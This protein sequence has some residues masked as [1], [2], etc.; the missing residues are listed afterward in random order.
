MLYLGLFRR[1]VGSQSVATSKQ[2]ARARLWS[3]NPRWTAPSLVPSSTRFSTSIRRRN[4][5]QYNL[6]SP[7]ND[8]VKE[9]A[10]TTTSQALPGRV[11]PRLSITFTCTVTDCGER[12]THEFS[13]RA[14]TKGIVLVQCPKCKNRW[15]LSC[16]V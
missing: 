4:D 7:K 15:V 14:Y 12:S 1:L 8:I 16:E 3:G 6:A 10:G 2:I 5:N 9:D 13:K 11:E